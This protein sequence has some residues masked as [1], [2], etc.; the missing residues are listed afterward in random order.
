MNV[1]MHDHD[2]EMTGGFEF[3]IDAA[4]RTLLWY[5]AA[6][7]EERLRAIVTERL[8][9]QPP[10]KIDDAIVA[11][12]F[13]AFRTMKLEKAVVEI[14]YHAT[15]GIKH[16]PP[17]S[18]LEQCSA[19]PARISVRASATLLYKNHF[20]A[21]RTPIVDRGRQTRQVENVIRDD[22]EY[23]PERGPIR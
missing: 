3:P 14:S 1:K 17:G 8:A 4:T 6:A 11:T 7:R 20:H 22:E 13:F 12:Y 16:P 19:K 18:L 23:T 21:V 10:P 9:A 5:D 2:N 15:S